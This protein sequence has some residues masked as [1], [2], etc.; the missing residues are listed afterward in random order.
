KK[1]VKCSGTAPCTYCSKRE[2]FCR[3]PEA[4]RRR[5]YSATRV[6][7]LEARLARYEEAHADVADGASE[8]P[9]VVLRPSCSATTA[10]SRGTARQLSGTASSLRARRINKMTFSRFEALD[11]HLQDGVALA[12]SPRPNIHTG[13]SLSSSHTFV[14]R[15]Q[16]LVANCHRGSTSS[17]TPSGTTESLTTSPLS[18]VE[19]YTRLYPGSVETALIPEE[20]DAYRYLNLIV[21]CVGQTQRLV[22][23]RECSDLLAQFYRGRDEAAALPVPSYLLVLL[24]LATGR[25]FAGEFDGPERTPGTTIFEYAHKNLPTLAELLP[26][27]RTG[28]ELL[29]MTAAYL[30]NADRRQEAYLYVSSAA[31]RLAIAHGYHRLSG[32]K[33]LLPS[34]M[35]QVNRLWWTIYMQEKRLAA[36]TGNP[37]GINE[38]VIEVI[39]PEESPGF[40]PAGPICINAKIARLTGCIIA[41]LYSPKVQSEDVFVPNVMAI[42]RSLHEISNDLPADFTASFHDLSPRLS[43]KTA[44]SLHLMLYQAALLTIRP[45][46]LHVAQRILNGDYSNESDVTSSCMS[47]LSR[48]CSEAAKR[49]LKV[50]TAL[51]REGMLTPFGFTDF[52][53]TF[54]AAF[55]MILAV[56]FDTAC[57]AEQMINPTDDLNE[58]LRIL[59]HLADC[60]NSVAAERVR[61]VQGMWTYLSGHLPTLSA[62]GGISP[63][64]EPQII[65]EGAPMAQVNDKEGEIG[66]SDAVSGKI[67]KFQGRHGQ[68]QM[69]DDETVVGQ[70]SQAKETEGRPLESSD[71]SL[72]HDIT[73]L[74]L[75]NAES[76]NVTCQRS[77]GGEPDECFNYFSILENGDWAMTGEDRVDFAELGRHI[78]GYEKWSL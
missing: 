46:M 7:E 31:L 2:L 3:M 20:E 48:T 5:L 1:K 8:V 34:E 14:S 53:A 36:A 67:P 66:I 10:E 68:N 9:P 70:G 29:G 71:T 38:E 33:S 23:G 60:G 63:S 40:G 69:I 72:W 18:P 15:V 59:K 73:L 41:T 76:E 37:S 45:I 39:L 35:V 43:M 4:T 58:A 61:E 28:V 25:L 30:Q 49:L 16:N 12:S 78:D 42:M 11:Q 24:I 77:E 55:I 22:D 26:Y 32:T 52:D 47:R 65:G 50:V 13:T 57:T 44:A 56:I 62:R 74:W 64:L 27:K 51:H 6:E 75:P 54:S 21:L 19:S 17:A